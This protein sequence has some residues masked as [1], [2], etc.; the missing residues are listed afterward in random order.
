MDA[1]RRL[2]GMPEMRV[3]GPRKLEAQVR[4]LAILEMAVVALIRPRDQKREC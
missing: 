1:G 4:L 3:L 2:S